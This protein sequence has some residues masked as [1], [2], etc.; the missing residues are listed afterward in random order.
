MTLPALYLL[1]APPAPPPPPLPLEEILRR[2]AENQQRSDSARARI[3]YHQSVRTRLL[4]GGGKLARE[5]S[6]Q[7]TVAPTATGTEK[8]LL[9]VAG[10]YE[11]HGKLHPYTDSKFRH[12]GVDL[13]GELADDLTD[14]LVDNK[15]SRDGLSR[16]LFPLTADEQRHYDF[17]F[18]GYQ[19]VQGVQAIRLAFS[20][21]KRP[22]TAEQKVSDPKPGAPIADAPAAGEAEA[23]KPKDT[24]PEDSKSGDG[25]FDGRPWSGTVLIHP[26]EFQPISVVTSLSKGIPGWVRVV[27]GINLK[28]LGFSLTYRKVAGGLWFPSTYGSEFFLRVFFGYARNVTMSME[29]SDFRLAS[30]E[31]TITY[32]EDASA[33]RQ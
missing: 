17:R 21:R 14:G 3:V 22:K 10:Q 29:N 9:S 23:A 19:S 15:K 1:L 28:Q 30:A 18:D 20:P 16:D 5:E 8:E 27:F 33:D 12:K 13:D 4:R 24:G 31:S 32:S 25:D 7:Y 11:K 6:R 26:D 2:V